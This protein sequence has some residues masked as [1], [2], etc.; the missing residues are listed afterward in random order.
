MEYRD[1]TFG[2]IFAFCCIIFSSID[3]PVREKWSIAFEGL[4]KKHISLS[5][6]F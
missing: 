3:I 1:A 6:G 5:Q 4:V 2:R